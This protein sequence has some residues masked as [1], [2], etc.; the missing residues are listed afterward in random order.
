MKQRVRTRMNNYGNVTLI[1]HCG[2]DLKVVNS[3]RISLFK[4]DDYNTYITDRD[5]KLIEYLAEHKH[6]SPFEH[7]FITFHIKC[8]LFIAKHIMRHRT[9]SYNEVSRRYTSELIEF[10]Y[11][12]ELRQQ[13]DKNLQASTDD[14]V[15]DHDKALSIFKESFNKSLEDY[16]RLIML[17]VCREQARAVLN[18]S[19]FTT[20]YMSGNLHNF[21]KFLKLRMSPDAQKEI[22]WIAKDIYIILKELYPVSMKACFDE[23]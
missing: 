14:L 11:P 7:N 13:A 23:R 17:G 5:I 15:K 2:N 21:I 18:Q 16:Q 20:F 19:M 6:T 22:Q 10:Y 1:D 9:F 4:H 12:A 8:P 3:A